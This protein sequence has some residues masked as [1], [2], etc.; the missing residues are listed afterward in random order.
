MQLQR[1]PTLPEALVWLQS[2]TVG[3]SEGTMLSGLMR[4]G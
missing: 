2:P 3:H 1:E 4:E